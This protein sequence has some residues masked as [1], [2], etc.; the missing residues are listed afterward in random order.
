MHACRIDLQLRV[1]RPCDQ[2]AVAELID[3]PR[4]PVRPTEDLG[5]SAVLEGRRT[6]PAN[7][8][9]AMLDVG[10]GLVG[11]ERNEV[12][13]AAD[14]GAQGR[15]RGSFE[16]RFDLGLA[17]EPDLQARIC[18][19][20][21]RCQLEEAIEGAPGQVLCFVEDQQRPTVARCDAGQEATQCLGVALLQIAGIVRLCHVD[22]ECQS[23]RAQ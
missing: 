9:E 4:H 23:D 18:R 22:A 6:G 13:G 17:D 12:T 10:G 8:A 5:K 16:P 15:R 21:V 7:H 11:V 1:E 3:A 19:R 14:E 20:A 2:H